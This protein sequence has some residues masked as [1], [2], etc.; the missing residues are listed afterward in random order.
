MSFL[1]Y[2][3]KMVLF[4]KFIASGK[5]TKKKKQELSTQ[6]MDLCRNTQ[7]KWHENK[8]NIEKSLMEAMVFYTV[9]QFFLFSHRFD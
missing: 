7:K 5:S 9:Q 1:W 3:L 8:I 6:L 4:W 2:I